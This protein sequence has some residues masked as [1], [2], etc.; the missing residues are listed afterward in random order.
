MA[1]LST[2]DQET[3]RLS[4]Q[5][6]SLGNELRLHLLELLTK[7]SWTVGELCQ[8]TGYLQ[9]KIWKHLDELCKAGLVERVEH[10]R[11]LCRRVEPHRAA[12]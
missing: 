1:E 10:P 11:A 2:I 3:Q 9:P 8:A 5:F 12:L 4:K 7:D 6:E